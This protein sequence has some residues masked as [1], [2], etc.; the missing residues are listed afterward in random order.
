MACKKCGPKAGKQ[1]VKT[2]QEAAPIA[3]PTVEVAPA[4][5]KK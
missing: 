5:K 3:P 2:Q 1:S 4:K